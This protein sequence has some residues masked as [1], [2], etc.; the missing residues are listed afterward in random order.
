MWLRR[1]VPCFIA[2]LCSLAALSADGFAQTA[3]PTAPPKTA[4][5]TPTA[6]TAPTTVASQ[7]PSLPTGGVVPQLPLD[8][9]RP[10]LLVFIHG[11]TSASTPSSLE[12][13]PDD[14]T[15]PNDKNTLEF[16]RFYWG[17]D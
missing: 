11:I 6:P 4:P 10:T 17:Y 2:A 16:A 7:P 15:E 8:R 9:T 3:I 14:Y 1:V 12:P 13:D 5:I